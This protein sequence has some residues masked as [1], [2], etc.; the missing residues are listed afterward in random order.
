VD[1]FKSSGKARAFP[2]VC[3][4]ERRDMLLALK[5]LLKTHKKRPAMVIADLFY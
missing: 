1:G 5:I 3:I 4:C 2:L